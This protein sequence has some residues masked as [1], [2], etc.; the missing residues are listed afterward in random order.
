MV[1]ITKEE[2]N[3]LLKKGLVYHE[4]IMKTYNHDPHYYM[5]ECDENLKFLKEIQGELNNA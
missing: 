2:K 3:K 1:R 4:D 5:R